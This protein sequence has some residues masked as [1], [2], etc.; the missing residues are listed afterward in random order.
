MSEPDWASWSRR[1]ADP[2][3]LRLHEGLG[4][5]ERENEV[6]EIVSRS[7]PVGAVRVYDGDGIGAAVLTHIDSPVLRIWQLVVFTPPTSAVPHLSFESS[8]SE[9]GTWIS[10]DLVPRAGCLEEPAYTRHVYEPLSEPL[11]DLHAREDTRQALIR[12]R[13]RMRLSPWL[14]TMRLDA[15]SAVEPARDLCLLY[16]EHFLGLVRDGIPAEAAPSLDA[17][18]LAARDVEQREQLYS[19]DATANYRFLALIDS[20]DLVDHVQRTLRTAGR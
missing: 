16:T 2:V 3:L 9:R 11:W 12:A 5:R 17:A 1:I 13:H 14:A 10:L 7:G 18:A 8:G 19:W 20:E 4:L 15:E 6:R